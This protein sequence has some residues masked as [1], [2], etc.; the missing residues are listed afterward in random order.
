MGLP[1]QIFWLKTL[2]KNPIILYIGIQ[3]K[4]I[5]LVFICNLQQKKNFYKEKTKKRISTVYIWTYLFLIINTL[6]ST[7]QMITVSELIH[8]GK[9]RNAHIVTSFCLRL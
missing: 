9:Q 8:S 2:Q 6:C 4:W 7:N 1:S 5:T 3:D